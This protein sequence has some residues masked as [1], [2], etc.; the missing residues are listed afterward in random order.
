MRSIVTLFSEDKELVK[1]C[2]EI[3]A[4]TFGSGLTLE[5]QGKGRIEPGDGVCIWDF[6]PGET[7]LPPDLDSANLTKHLFLV[8][9]DH[10]G[11]LQDHLGTSQLNVVLKPVARATLTAFLGSAVQMQEQESPARINALRVERDEML[12]VLMQAN[13]R[14]QEYEQQRS[15]FLARSLHD[16]R[17]PL[18]TV[19][20]YCGLLL[21]EDPGPLTTE[22][23]EILKRMQHDV[24]RLSRLS[25]AM[26][27]LSVPRDV[28]QKPTWQSA[29]IR[30]SIE[31]ALLEVAPFL[32]DKRIS[33]S[34]ET[35]PPEFLLFEKS[36][37]EQALANLLDNACKFTPRDGAIEVRGYPIFWERRANQPAALERGSDRRASHTTAPNAYRVDIRDSGPEIPAARLAGIFEEFATYS[38]GHDRS[39]AG[40]GLAICRMILRRHRGRIWAESH[41]GG[42]LFSFVL[43]FQPVDPYSVAWAETNPA[44][45]VAGR[46]VES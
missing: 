39:G 10:L 15:N 8:H 20:G 5:T 46:S 33:V 36:Q 40:L 29:N 28:D 2:R 18:T 22:Q 4:Q 14:L 44:A 3:L 21:E 24:R 37:I 23:A 34:L 6:I 27:Q 11:A 13:L 41:P 1:F 30:E 32:E 38:G 42:V 19:G 25:T 26:F 7:L 31:H 43:P 12:Q 9:R 17:S 16:F 45:H 35:E